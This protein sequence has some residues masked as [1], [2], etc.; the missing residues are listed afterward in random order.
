MLSLSSF[1]GPR[2]HIQRSK[3]RGKKKTREEISF[4]GPPLSASPQPFP[5]CVSRGEKWPTDTE[6]RAAEGRQTTHTHLANPPRHP[7]HSTPHPSSCGRSHVLHLFPLP[8]LCVPTVWP[9]GA[10]IAVTHYATILCYSVCECVFLL[11]LFPPPNY[12][13]LRPYVVQSAVPSLPPLL[14]PIPGVL[15]LP[16]HPRRH[17]CVLFFPEHTLAVRI[18][19]DERRRKEKKKKRAE[20]ADLFS[21]PFFSLLFLQIQ[22]DKEKLLYELDNL[23][24]QLE[25]AQMSSNRFQ[26]EREDFQMDADRQRE[27]VDKLQVSQ[28]VPSS[29]DPHP[30]L[31]DP[32]VFAPLTLPATTYCSHPDAAATCP[33]SMFAPISSSSSPPFLFFSLTT[34]RFLFCYLAEEGGP[35]EP[36]FFSPPTRRLCV[37]LPY[38][39]S[40]PRLPFSLSSPISVHFPAFSSSYFASSFLFFLSFHGASSS[41]LIVLVSKETR[42]LAVSSSNVLPPPPHTCMA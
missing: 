11:P 8:P 1:H 19:L 40:P 18:R 16:P 37:P 33:Q 31:L 15:L 29:G 25:K 32:S 7:M 3:R 23:Q 28:G 42:G 17:S 5:F 26:T 4:P 35:T 30:L 24:N 9:T 2:S 41:F 6:K 34:A 12:R 13:A 22:A 27:K 38:R 10:R 21:S 39:I 20:G 36:F 14:N